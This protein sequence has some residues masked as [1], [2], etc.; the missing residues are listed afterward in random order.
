VADIVGRRLV[1]RGLGFLVMYFDHQIAQ[2][3]LRPHDTRSSARA[4]MG[5]LVP[6]AAGM[7]VLPALLIDGPTNDE[8]VATCVDIFLR[9][10]RPNHDQ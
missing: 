6:Q 8:H 7:I 5:M 9:G 3:R 4:F 1:A 2:G 10:L